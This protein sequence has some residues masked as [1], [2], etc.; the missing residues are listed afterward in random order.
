MITNI[1]AIADCT[2]TGLVAYA[3]ITYVAIKVSP[4]AI[5]ILV[6]WSNRWGRKMPE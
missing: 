4:A 5:Q 3:A 1:G 2:L 6:Q